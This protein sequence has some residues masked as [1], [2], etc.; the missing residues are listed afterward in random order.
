MINLTGA[1]KVTNPNSPNTVK[2]LQKFASLQLSRGVSED[3]VMQWLSEKKVASEVVKHILQEAEHGDKKTAAAKATNKQTGS[4]TVLKVQNLHKQ[5]GSTPI[6]SNINLDVSKGDILG[7]IGLSGS[8]KTTLLNTLLGLLP[9]DQGK[10]LFKHPSLNGYLAVNKNPRAIT[11]LVGYAPQDPSFYRRLT[12]KEN[13]AHFSSLFDV[14][15]DQVNSKAEYLLKSMDLW[16]VRNT[17]G[18]NLSGGQSRRLGIACSVIHDPSVVIFDEPTADLDPVIRKEIWKL[19]DNVHKTG[20][21]VVLT[22]HYLDELED[23][24]NKV[25]ILHK[26]TVVAFGSPKDLKKKFS[27]NEEIHLE[28]ESKNYKA[29]AT[30][31]KGSKL[32]VSKIK[33]DNDKLVIHTPK[34]ADVMYSVLHHLRQKKEKIVDVD[35]RKPS[36]DEVFESF[37]TRK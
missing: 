35:L 37:V 22:S 28:L 20:K 21:T 33:M 15:E 9:P 18:G 14:A 13:L 7:I 30:K 25:I 2:R 34:G 3:E 26:S 24:C 10:V 23:K 4:S 11:R 17:L 27:D 36:L 6:L 1:P 31:I 29:L 32:P 16:H 8:G 19:I 5:F 12:V